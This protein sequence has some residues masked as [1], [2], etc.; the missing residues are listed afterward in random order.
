MP[1]SKEKLGEKK[2]RQAENKVFIEGLLS[3]VDI[4]EITY[5]KNGV[6]VKALSGSIKVRVDQENKDG[7]ITTLEIPVHLF[8]NELNSKG[9]PNSAFKSTRT[10][11]D[12][13][14]SIASGGEEKATAVR[15]SGSSAQIVMNEYYDKNGN[16][17]SYP[18]IRG[19]FVNSI[20]RSKMIPKAE[21][22]VEFVVAKV[23]DSVDR[24][25]MPDGRLKIMGIVPQYGNKVD[26]MPFYAI[27]PN[28]ITF[29]KSYWA[30]GN[31][32]KMHGT[33]NFTSTVS[34]KVEEVAFGDPIVKH[35]TTNVSELIGT[36]GTNPLEGDLAFDNNEIKAALTQRNAD[37]EAQKAR[38]MSRTKQS[39]APAQSGFG[40][41]LG[42]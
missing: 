5:K 31:T 34:E 2:M 27:N 7:S 11:M 17:V 9:E 22:D 23:E 10:I 32:V 41:G 33:I 21:F 20:E 16:F 37:L 6:D 26:V 40:D 18:R 42:F 19:S 39:S 4:N 38:D 15:I 35:F 29:I 1:L 28:A 8:A 13:F 36:A 24:E 3:E 25:G 30:E 12:S 14:T